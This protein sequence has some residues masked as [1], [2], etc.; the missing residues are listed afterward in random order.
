MFKGTLYFYNLFIVN[1][2]LFDR[3]GHF[4]SFLLYDF[5]TRELYESF[6]AEE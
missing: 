6:I 1:F 5:E 2:F 3:F 4:E